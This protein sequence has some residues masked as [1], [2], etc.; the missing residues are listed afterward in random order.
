MQ[1]ETD[2]KVRGIAIRVIGEI[3][4]DSTLAELRTFGEQE[5]DAQV[6][7]LVQEAEAKI[8]ARQPHSDNSGA[9]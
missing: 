9:R 2:P 1:S 6:K 5:K 4:D 3:G 7:A 8:E